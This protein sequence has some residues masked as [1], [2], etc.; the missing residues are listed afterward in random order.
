MVPWNV[1]LEELEMYSSYHG[2]PAW[3]LQLGCRNTSRLERLEVSG[4]KHNLL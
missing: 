3:K 4:S 1:R 2:Q